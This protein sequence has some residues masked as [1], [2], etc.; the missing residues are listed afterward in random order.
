MKGELDSGSHADDHEHCNGPITLYANKA[1]RS[2]KVWK[3]V[4]DLF[5]KKPLSV[6]RLG[7]L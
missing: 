3:L 2:T 7:S 4:S 1:S 6:F 5:E